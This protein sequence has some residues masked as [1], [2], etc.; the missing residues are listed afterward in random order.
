MSWLVFIYCGNEVSEIE[1]S[2]G[3]VATIGSGKSDSVRLEGCGLKTRHVTL[4]A[5]ESGVRL[6]SL[7]RVRIGAD[8]VT[9]RVLNAGDIARVTNDVSLTLFE[10]RRADYPSVSLSGVTEVSIGRSGR[11]DISLSGAQVSSNHATLCK[12]N[13]AW[14]ISDDGSRNGTYVD[15]KLTSRSV[16]RDNAVVF[17]GGW[18]LRYA[19]GELHFVQ[20]PDKALI[21]SKLASKSAAGPGSEA[22][23][24]YFMKS[25]RL[26]PETETLE[27]EISAPPRVGEK[28]SVSWLS[29][30]LPPIL[31]IVV[32][33]AVAMMMDNSGSGMGFKS[34]WVTIPMSLI[35]IVIAAVNYNSQTKKWRDNSRTANE[36][37]NAYLEEREIEITEAETAYISALAGINPG[38][39]RC[40]SIAARRER[41]LWERSLT[42][43]DFLAV[44][45]GTGLAPSNVSIK[46]PHSQMTLEEDLLLEKAQKLKERHGDLSGVPVTLPFADINIVGLTGSRDALQNTLRAVVCGVAAHHS[47]EDVKIAAVFPERERANWHFLRWLPH[48][49]DDDRRERLLACDAKG[50]TALL[51]GID[52]ILKARLRDTED[53]DKEKSKKAAPHY[54]VIIA[55]KRLAEGAGVSLLPDDKGLSITVVYAYGDIGLLPGECGAIAECGGAD[56][57]IRYKSGAGRVAF[58]PDKVSVPMMDDFCRSLAPVR[59]RV[60]SKKAGMPEY[61]PLLAGLGVSKVEELGV[62]ERWNRSR[63]FVSIAAPIGIRENGEVFF[64]DIHEKGMGPHGIVAGATRWGKSETLTT[65]LLSVALNFHPQEVSFVLIDFKGD[66]LSGILMDLPHVAGR[67]SN[68]NDIASIERNLRSLQG[69][70]LRRQRVFMETKQENIHKYQEAFRAGRVSEPMPYLI[71]VIDE[72]AELKTRFP[73]QMNNFIQIAR[74]GGSLGVYMVLATQSPGGGIVSGQVSANSRFRICLKTA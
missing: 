38:P 52:D 36:K 66:G 2:G 29:I 28:P 5:T 27:T 69:E 67:I 31:M 12:R 48:V 37:Y 11:K 56:G 41:R 20:T 18:K 17:M 73:E 68:V 62:L 4:T 49:W 40:V 30:L 35:S 19:R 74:V 3:A 9:A 55:D 14:E 65:W 10:K 26:K 45:V 58:E 54:F 60:S 39:G 71:I 1:L 44:R 24:P 22:A 23:Y 59:F 43:D 63:P 15:G 47:Y 33:I 13:G 21:A 53:K 72:F 46:L 51:R 16:L 57:A 8:D 42:D 7:E 70:L 50:A 32:M 64:F 25:P 34:F 6:S 61:I